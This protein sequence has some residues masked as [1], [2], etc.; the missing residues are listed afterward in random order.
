MLFADDIAFISEIEKVFLI[1][2]VGEKLW[3]LKDF[4]VA[5]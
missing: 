3:N 4:E 1:M 5:E 2:K